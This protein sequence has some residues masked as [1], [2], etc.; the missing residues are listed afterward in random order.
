MKVL[1]HLFVFISGEKGATGRDGEKGHVGLPGRDGLQ[2]QMGLQG[3][4]GPRG[5]IGIRG[6]KGTSSFVIYLMC[7]YT[8]Y[9]VVLKLKYN[10]IFPSLNSQS[11][12]FLGDKGEDGDA[13]VSESGRKLLGDMGRGV[14]HPHNARR[15]ICPTIFELVAYVVGQL[16]VAYFRLNTTQKCTCGYECSVRTGVL[17][18]A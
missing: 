10:N 8:P 13:K 2:G 17:R 1:L 4:A 12:I 16:F 5:P 3:Q 15:R 18:M 11:Y 6:L 14:M 9:F 7:L